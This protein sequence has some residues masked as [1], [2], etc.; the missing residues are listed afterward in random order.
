MLTY[1][2]P[3]DPTYVLFYCFIENKKQQ[4]QQQ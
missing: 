3:E 2:S 1:I 4:Q